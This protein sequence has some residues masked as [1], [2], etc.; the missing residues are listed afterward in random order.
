MRAAKDPTKAILNIQPALIA[1]LAHRSL[2][3]VAARACRA[4]A[5]SGITAAIN[6]LPGTIRLFAAVS[7]RMQMCA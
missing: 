1:A 4:A 6:Y 2:W 3:H 5:V 7:T